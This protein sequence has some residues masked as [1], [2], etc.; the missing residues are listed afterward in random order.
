LL[1]VFGR[2]CEH[3]SLIVGLSNPDIDKSD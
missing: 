3:T 2:K 1:Y